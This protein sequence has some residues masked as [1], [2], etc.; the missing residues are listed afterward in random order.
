[1][2]PIVWLTNDRPTDYPFGLFGGRFIQASRLLA[3][4]TTRSLSRECVAPE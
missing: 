2:L 3:V 4:F 1:M